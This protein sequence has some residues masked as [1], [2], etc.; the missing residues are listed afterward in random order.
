M[1]QVKRTG[2]VNDFVT[3]SWT[4]PVAEL[5]YLLRCR[6][7]LR[8][9][10]PRTSR[11]SVLSHASARFPV[12]AVLAVALPEVLPRHQQ[13]ASYE[14]GRRDTGCSLNF[15][16]NRKQ[17]KIS[18]SCLGKFYHSPYKPSFLQEEEAVCWMVTDSLINRQRI[19]R[20]FLAG[21]LVCVDIWLW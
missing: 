1:K 2:D 17:Q 16:E 7:K 9:T 3:G 21:D 14:I 19:Y 15:P 13:H 12:Y 11:R 8:A 6:Q 18:L 10:G 20:G 4:L 5:Y